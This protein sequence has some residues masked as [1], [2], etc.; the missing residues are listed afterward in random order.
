MKYIHLSSSTDYKRGYKLNLT[1]IKTNLYSIFE[2]VKQRPHSLCFFFLLFNCST[3]VTSSDSNST[4]GVEVGCS[5]SFLEASLVVEVVVDLGT[6]EVELR[7]GG[8]GAML[9]ARQIAGG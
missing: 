4:T 8:G 3:L 5:L 2:D 7:L 1:L 6:K 9:G